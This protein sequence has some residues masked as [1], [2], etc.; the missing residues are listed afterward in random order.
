MDPMPITLHTDLQELPEQT[1]LFEGHL[2]DDFQKA[3]D[4]D[5]AKLKEATEKAGWPAHQPGKLF[6][7]YVVTS[8]DRVELKKVI[9]RAASLAKVVV[10]FYKDAKTA[11]GHAVVKFHVA[12]R[13]VKETP[14]A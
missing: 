14:A 1:E 9:R 13:P 10:V 5:V 8:T 6:H 7:R 11:E 2:R 3:V 12:K 4:A